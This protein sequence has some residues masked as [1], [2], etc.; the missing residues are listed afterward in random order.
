MDPQGRLG[1]KS[2]SHLICFLQTSVI[3]TSTSCFFLLKSVYDL[4]HLY[5]LNVIIYF[6]LKSLIKNKMLYPSPIW[7]MIIIFHVVKESIK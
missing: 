4:C 3:C 7:K 1:N 6:L 2:W 5:N